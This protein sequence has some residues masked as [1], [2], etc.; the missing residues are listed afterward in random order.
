MLRKPFAVL[1]ALFGGIIVVISTIIIGIAIIIV[2]KINPRAGSIDKLV[3]VWGR[4]FLIAAWST[5]KVEGREKIDSSKSYILVANHLSELDV[6]SNFLISPVGIRFL[7]KKEL[8]RLPLLPTIMRSMGMVETNRQAGK[9]AHEEINKQIEYTI[10]LGHSLMIY[11]E[12]TRSRA[13]ELAHF[14]KGAFRIAI[15][16]QMDVVPISIDGSYEAWAADSIFVYGGP[17]TA[18][19]HDPI[20]VADMTHDD[21]VPLMEQA[22]TVIEAGL[23]AQKAARKK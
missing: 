7:A 22:H 6:A 19:V 5:L 3:R 16:N 14:K 20:S 1:R 18:R 17:I 15:D 4:I 2:A 23:A 9:A 8:Y 21:I 13:G 10:S 12:G 11:P